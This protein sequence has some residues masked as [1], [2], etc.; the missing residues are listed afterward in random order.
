MRA[1][2][3]R[4]YRGTPP[5]PPPHTHIHTPCNSHTRLGPASQPDAPTPPYRAAQDTPA[6]RDAAQAGIPTD[7]P[8]QLTPSAPSRVS[9]GAGEATPAGRLE[10]L[11]AA[12]DGRQGRGMQ[13]GRPAPSVLLPSPPAVAAA[14]PRRHL[15][16]ERQ[17]YAS[18]AAGGSPGKGHVRAPLLGSAASN[19]SVGNDSVSEKL[20]NI[21]STFAALRS[22]SGL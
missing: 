20:K 22:Q 14:P 9:N 16:D 7:V 11:R 5:L 1:R 10:D 2:P 4:N 19:G 12:T 17:L 6:G 15:L 8:P 13:F 3:L 21:H 18:A